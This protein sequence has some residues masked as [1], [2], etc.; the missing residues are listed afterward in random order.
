MKSIAKF[1]AICSKFA[2]NGRDYSSVIR[3]IQSDGRQVYTYSDG[4]F[5]VC[6]TARCNDMEIV[7][8]MMIPM[9]CCSMSPSSYP[10]VFGAV[11]Y[12]MSSV[13]NP[14]DDHISHGAKIKALLHAQLR[15]RRSKLTPIAEGSS[16]SRG[17]RQAVSPW[18][19]NL[20]KEVN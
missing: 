12:D 10:D 9:G 19:F 8:P 18:S 1:I 11:G 5:A 16:T 3:F 17:R 13:K 15:R 4:F 14:T 2:G 20:A 6:M 7:S